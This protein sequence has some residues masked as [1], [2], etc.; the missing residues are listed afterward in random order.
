MKAARRTGPAAAGL[1]RGPERPVWSTGRGAGDERELVRSVLA[2]DE[3]SFLV[4]VRRYHRAVWSV[5]RCRAADDAGARE[6]EHRAWATVLERLPEWPASRSPLRGW[7]VRVVASVASRDRHRWT[8]AARLADEL[9]RAA[10][11]RGGVPCG[12]PGEAGEPWPAGSLRSRKLLAVLRRA[13]D[14][15][16][17]LQRAVFTIRDVTG[18]SADDACV[19]LELSDRDQRALLHLARAALWRALEE[20]LRPGLVA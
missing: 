5:V 14:A 9:G 19:A 18:C 3:P 10:A 2:G 11:P 13:V 20:R 17:P 7:V 12:R 15:L 4:M 1:A 6:L 16:P 8:S